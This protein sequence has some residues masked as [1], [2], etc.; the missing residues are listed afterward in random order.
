MKNIILG[1]VLIL[2][3]PYVLFAIDDWNGK[4]LKCDK[5]SLKAYANGRR[6]NPKEGLEEFE[7]T[8][9]YIFTNDYHFIRMTFYYM[10]TSDSIS[11]LDIRHGT[12]GPIPN[13]VGYM[14]FAFQRTFKNIT[15]TYHGDDEFT[16]K[17][18]DSQQDIGRLYF[19]RQKLLLKEAPGHKDNHV[20]T[21]ECKPLSSRDEFESESMTANN[22]MFDNV[23]EEWQKTTNE[24]KENKM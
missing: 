17:E 16:K 22:K 8:E 7:N 11:H 23:K 18:R 1:F 3:S 15:Y 9:F 24:R 6:D 13:M 5:K 19:D 10:K 21:R 2:I 20:L 4:F 14:D 12:Y